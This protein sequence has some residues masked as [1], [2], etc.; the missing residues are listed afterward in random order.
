MDFA[1]LD[2]LQKHLM[3]EISNAMRNE[4]AG[5]A[6]EVVKDRIRKD[7]ESHEPALYERTGELRESVQGK[8]EQISK[9]VSR[10]KIDHDTSK[11]RPQGENQHKSVVDGRP[12]N[13][14][15]PE[16]V[17]DGKSGHIFGEGFWTEPRPYMDN[18]KTE[19][20]TYNKHV[21]SLKKGLQRN[22]LNVTES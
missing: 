18:A 21:N 11:I 22:G 7:V 5:E 17:H 3:K 4:V 15:L 12:S 9:N 10:L 1:N 6:V 20:E 2:D 13:D 19:I 14:V 16:I 8:E